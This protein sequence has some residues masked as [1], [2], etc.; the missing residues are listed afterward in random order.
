MAD[1]IN[2]AR[3]T[4]LNTQLTTLAPEIRGLDDLAKTSVSPDLAARIV[5]QSD[6]LKRRRDLIQAELNGM[7]SV[8]ALHASLLADGYPALPKAS[9]M[10]SLFVELQEEIADMQAAVAVFANEATS[11]NISLGAPVS[12]STP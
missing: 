7:D 6:T 3:R 10:D 4:E 8:N 9:V 11:L 12:K 2:A 5:A 1:D